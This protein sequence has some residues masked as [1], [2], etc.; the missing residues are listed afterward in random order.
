MN[1]ETLDNLLAK[2]LCKCNVKRYAIVPSNYIDIIDLENNL[3]LV[4]VINT[5]PSNI[6]TYGHWLL[7][8]VT[9][10]YDPRFEKENVV[11]PTDPRGVLLFDSYGKDIVKEYNIPNLN[12]PNIQNIG[13][14]FQSDNSRTCGLYVVLLAYIL[15]LNLHYSI[16]HTM[17]DEDVEQR[18][19]NDERIVHLF[20]KKLKKLR[21][22]CTK[23]Q[24]CCTKQEFETK[25]DH[26]L[27]QGRPV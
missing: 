14:C 1:T 26:V 8:F 17:F 12:I 21:S 24:T 6:R 23:G 2:L 18:E 27:D 11:D 20:R 4:L 19:T 25:Q 5:S 15:S 7:A 13:K 10:V 16:F 9:K 22:L 3:P